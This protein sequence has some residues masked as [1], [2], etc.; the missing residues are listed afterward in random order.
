M[1]HTRAAR[2]VRHYREYEGTTAALWHLHTVALR[3]PR[4]RA[5][6]AEVDIRRNRNI[7]SEYL[8]KSDIKI[9]GRSVL[10]HDLLSDR[11][12]YLNGTWII[13][14][15][16]RISLLARRINRILREAV[17]TIVVRSRRLHVRISSRPRRNIRTLNGMIL[18]VV[19]RSSRQRLLRSSPSLLYAST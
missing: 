8:H 1:T 17:L 7:I 5:A 15:N 12:I 18:R 11:I 2:L 13:I 10:P 16:G 9:R 19:Q 6:N 14:T 3:R 4:T